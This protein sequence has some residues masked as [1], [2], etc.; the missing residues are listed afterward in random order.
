MEERPLIDYIQYK[1]DRSFEAIEDIQKM[2]DNGMLSAAMN[3]IYYAGFYIVSALL[4]LD[5][6]STSKHRQLIAYFN[7]EYIKTGKIPVDIGEI[8][9]ESYNNRL[10]ADYHDFVFLTKTQ[11]EEFYDQIKEFV[12]LID[13]MIKDRIKE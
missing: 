1:K 8:L 10:A 9:N 2:I 3:R 7:K 12:S 4:L 13:K 5:G 6:F 11:V